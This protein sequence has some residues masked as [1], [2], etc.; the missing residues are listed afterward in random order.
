MEKYMDNFLR[1]DRFNGYLKCLLAMK[2]IFDTLLARTILLFDNV[3][4]Y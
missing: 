1:I 2:Y 4:I 3:L